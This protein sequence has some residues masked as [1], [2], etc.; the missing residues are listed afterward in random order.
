MNEKEL[1]EQAEMIFNGVRAYGIL[2]GMSDSICKTTQLLIDQYVFVFQCVIQL[3][4]EYFVGDTRVE[5]EKAKRAT[6]PVDVA[7]FGDYFFNLHDI[8]VVVD[9]LEYW[10]KR[11]TKITSLGQE[12]LD[13]HDYAVK[14]KEC[15]K[16]HINLFNWLNG[17]PRDAETSDLAADERPAPEE[18]GGNNG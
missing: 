15:G 6:H 10:V 4:L 5:D 1:K 7:M 3:D 8:R 2:Q 14:Q 11:Y 18:K 16:T 17:C 9:N 12:I 13:W